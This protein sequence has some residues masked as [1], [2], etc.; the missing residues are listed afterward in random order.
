MSEK[1]SK[2]NEQ[3]MQEKYMEFQMLERQTKQLQAQLEQIQSQIADVMY[4]QQ[5]I[6]ELKTVKV[7]KELFVPIGSGIFVNAELK[8]NCD[9]LINV[10]CGVVVKKSIESAAELL[11]AQ[12]AQMQL[13]EDER[14]KML[15]EF[16]ESAGRI[17]QELAKLVEGEA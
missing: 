17:E 11:S 2:S 12:I 3:L 6:V 13:I 16:S 9:V 8:N 4:L 5:S 10:G 15:L 7:G 1:K 14:T